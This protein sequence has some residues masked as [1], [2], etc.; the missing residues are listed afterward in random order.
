M[1]AIQAEK[2]RS[3]LVSM[4][5]VLLCVYSLLNG[6]H[7]PPW[8]C[9]WPLNNLQFELQ[10]STYTWILFN[11]KYYHTTQSKVVWIHGQRRTLVKEGWLEVKRGLSTAQR[12]DTP[13]SVLFKDHVYFHHTDENSCSWFPNTSFWT[14]FFFNISSINIHPALKS[15]S[16]SNIPASMGMM[17]VLF[18]LYSF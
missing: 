11:S 10:E 12:V 5:P 13:N 8:L 2:T 18:N 6:K 7:C 9:S 16:S 4:E 3:L 14:F 17:R 15:T 1:R